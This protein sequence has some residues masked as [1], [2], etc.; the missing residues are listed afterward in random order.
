MLKKLCQL[1]ALLALPIAVFGQIKTTLFSHDDTLRG[2]Y[3]ADRAWWDLTFYDLKIR[4]NPADSSVSGSNTIY[5]KVLKPAQ[6]LQLDLQPPLSISRIEQ[7]GQA[8]NFEKIG[9]NA[10]QI[11]LTAAQRKGSIKSLTAFFGGKPRVARNAPWDGG[12]SWDKDA[13]GSP[14]VATS[15]QGLGASAWWVCKDHMADEVDSMAISVTVPKDLTDISNG[16]LRKISKNAD[17]TR[18]D[19]KSTRLNSS[20][21]RLSRMPSSA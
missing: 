10:Y 16:R 21:L 7:D 4:V 18:T 9:T 8:V 11:H 12:F 2:T 20:H 15:C 1:L 13:T 3:N 19:R 17:R 14:F 5:Y 6:T